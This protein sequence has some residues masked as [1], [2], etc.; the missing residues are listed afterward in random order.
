MKY[1]FNL[2]ISAFII[3]SLFSCKKEEDITLDDTAVDQTDQTNDDEKEETDD[4]ESEDEDPSKESESNYYPTTVGTKYTYSSPQYDTY[5]VE[6]T[7]TEMVSGIEYTTIKTITDTQI[8]K[9]K[10]LST[11]NEAIVIS[12]APRL[13]SGEFSLKVIDKTKNL[14][15]SWIVGNIDVNQSGIISSSE[16]SAKFTDKLSKLEVNGIIY[17]DVIEITMSTT[18]TVI[19][20]EEYKKLIGEDMVAYLEQNLA[21]QNKSISQKTYYANNIGMIKQTSDDMESLYAE[22][23]ST[24]F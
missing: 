17:D 9:S 18:T 21:S 15:E 5:T 4:K 24:N 23:V 10:S 11:A 19:L 16:Y 13:N 8:T 2:T 6:Y 7:G 22:L 20:S 1:L 14:N 3:L 12:T